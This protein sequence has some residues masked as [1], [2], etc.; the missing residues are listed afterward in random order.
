MS[1]GY[2]HPGDISHRRDE[3][4]PSIP[5]TPGTAEQQKGNAYTDNSPLQEFPRQHAD[6][7]GRVVIEDHR[8]AQHFARSAV[9]LLARGI[10]DEVNLSGR[11]TSSRTMGVLV[12]Q[13]GTQCRISEGS[14][15]FLTPN[16]MI[17]LVGAGRFERPTPCA[18]VVVAE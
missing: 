9:A 13:C 15:R 16:F 12:T 4:D 8:L 11:Y 5:S 10:G 1:R 7:Y 6:D 2:I 18:Q 3:A 14:E 17:L